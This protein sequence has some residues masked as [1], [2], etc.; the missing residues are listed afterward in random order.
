MHGAA[1][2]LAERLLSQNSE[3][4]LILTTDM[5]DVAVFTSLIRRRYAR[6][7]VAIYFH[8]NQ[9]CYPWSPGDMDAKRQR[10][11]HY[12]FI[13]YTSSL[14]ADRVYFNSNYHRETFL[15]AL[16]EFLDAYPDFENKG[17]VAAIEAKSAT[18]PLGLDLTAFDPYWQQTEEA[19]DVPLLLWNHR[20]EYDKGPV[21]FC[22][23][24]DALLERGLEFQVALLGQQPSAEPPYFAKARERW[25]ERVAAYGTADS[26]EDYAAWLWRADIL[27]V[28]SEQDFFGGSVVEAV[29]CGCHPLLPKRLAYPNHFDVNEY[30]ISYYESEDEAVERLAELIANEG[31][32]QPSPLR[33]KAARYDWREMIERYDR[34][35]ERMLATP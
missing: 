18:L 24:L 10:D 3:Y 23:L 9:L 14:A 15:A 2:T 16:P 20:W 17:T 26:F 31:W 25:G 30:P 34:E 21:A 12:V 6:T 13:N 33:E 1:I 29:Y 35:F 7:P 19:G 11:R 28:T 4:D 27:P 32:K 5:L 22:R 8:E